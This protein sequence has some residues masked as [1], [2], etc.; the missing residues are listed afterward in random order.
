MK[1][2]GPRPVLKRIKKYFPVQPGEDDRQ[3]QL[4]F[5][6]LILFHNAITAAER[7]DA[8]HAIF[9]LALVDFR[10]AFK[11]PNRAKHSGI[12]RAQND[13]PRNSPGNYFEDDWTNPSFSSESSPARISLCADG[14]RSNAF[15]TREMMSSDPCLPSQNSKITAAVLL[16]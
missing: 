10:I 1:N 9:A 16:R 4:L 15:A 12:G 6:S 11:V 13:P 3:I 14:P 7:L 5:G 2:A 8:E